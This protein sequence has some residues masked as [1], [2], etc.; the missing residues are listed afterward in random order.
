MRGERAMNSRDGK[1]NRKTARINTESQSLRAQNLRK[2]KGERHEKA[3]NRNRRLRANITKPTQLH[4][5]VSR[6]P[7][8]R[9]N[10]KKR[11]IYNKEGQTMKKQDVCCK[12]PDCKGKQ[13]YAEQGKPLE[14]WQRLGKMFG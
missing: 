12:W 13:L 6:V 5:P 4:K 8:Q 10:G 7:F 11:K 1:G 3:N 2:A 9:K 14:P